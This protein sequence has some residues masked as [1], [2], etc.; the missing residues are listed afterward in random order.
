M[1][2]N[3]IADTRISLSWTVYRQRPR[4]RP[5][6]LTERRITGVIQRT[7]TRPSTTKGTRRPRH[8]YV[9]DR[10][11]HCTPSHA[12]KALASG[13][14]LLSR[15]TELYGDVFF[16]H[17][18]PRYAREAA[19]G[20][21][22]AQ[23]GTGG[24]DRP[25][26]RSPSRRGR[27]PAVLGNGRTVTLLTLDRPYRESQG[28]APDR[29]AKRSPTC[30]SDDR[31][32]GPCHDHIC[33]HICGHTHR[34][35]LR[36]RGSAGPAHATGRGA[37]LRDRAHRIAVFFVRSPTHGPSASPPWRRRSPRTCW[38]RSR[39]GCSRLPSP[40]R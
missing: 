32:T 6:L 29:S 15:I 1:F 37:P 25:P 17:G 12:P 33:I 7:R 9:I 20:L 10:P 39:P 2:S 23:L 22:S 16:V 28:L 5:C 38:P 14:G 3:G 11:L 8:T 21:G 36:L 24:T 27:I 18:R 30:A 26:Q 4:Q 19:L 40:R 31:R 13:T 35:G 34:D